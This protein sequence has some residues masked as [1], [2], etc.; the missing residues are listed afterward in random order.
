MTYLSAG[1]RRRVIVDAAVRVIAT[2]GLARATTRR[3]AEQAG[4]PLGTLHYCFRNKDELNLLILGRGRATMLAA[5]EG[6]DRRA[7]FEATVR[8]VVATYWRW[9]RDHHGLHLALM[10]LLMWA[11]RNKETVG[12][13]RDLWAEVNA[14]L[15]GDLIDSALTAAAGRDGLRTAVPVP[16]LARFLIHRMDGLVF[17]FAETS[18]EASCERQT[19][20]LADALILLALPRQGLR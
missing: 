6:L 13:G 15:G 16:E 8:E 20:L 1:E 3:I 17:E 5:F 2:E 11:I 19:V 9:I 10:E 12:P 7:G 18:D 14:P 4:V